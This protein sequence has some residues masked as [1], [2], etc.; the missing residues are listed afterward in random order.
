MPHVRCSKCQGRTTLPRK[1]TEYMRLP[2]C[3]HCGRKMVADPASIRTP[4]YY[5]DRYRST[6]ERG[7]KAPKP[8]VPGAGGCDGYHFPHRRGS[9]WCIHNPSLT[10]E[11]LRER[12][13]SGGRI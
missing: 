3:R 1:P 10:T 9:R 12:H 4:H 13:E 7:R 8:C 6:R 2:R 11:E 5:L